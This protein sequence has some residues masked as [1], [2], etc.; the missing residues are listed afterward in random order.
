MAGADKRAQVLRD[1]LDY[2]VD[3]RNLDGLAARSNIRQVAL[4]HLV[5]PTRNAIME[6]I[7]TRD[8]ATNVV[9]THD[10]MRFWLP[11]NSDEIRVN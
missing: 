4:Y 2:H 1:V 11:A 3:T 5:P 6:K 10:G 7:F 9:M 8:I